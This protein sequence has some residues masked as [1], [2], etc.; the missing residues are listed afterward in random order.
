MLTK[1]ALIFFGLLFLICIWLGRRTRV[2]EP[3]EGERISVED[4]VILL[5]A[6]D[7]SVTGDFIAQNGGDYLG[8][9]E[10]ADGTSDA[11]GEDAVKEYLTYGQY[12]EIRKMVDGD[13]MNLPDYAERYEEE[14]PL[15]KEDWYA[16]Y[17]LML[18]HLDTESSIWETTVFLLK[19]DTE[20]GTAYTE[21]G[22][23][24][25][26]WQYHSQAFEEN[27]LQ[28]MRVYVKNSDLL[29]VI[30]V[31]PDKYEVKNVWIME[32]TEGV[33]ECFYHQIAF[34]AATERPVERERVA[35]LTFQNGRI[36]DAREKNEKVHGKLLRMTET[37]VEI[38]GCG[39][40]QIA[41]GMEV[42]K[43]YGSM[44]TQ[45]R[46]DLRI[47]YA[48]TDYVIDRGQ[49]CAALICEEETADRIR[50]LLKNTARNSN[51]FDTA[52]LVVDGETIQVNA[53]DLEVGERRSYQCAAL[54]D[55]ILLN[56][57]GNT[58]E[59]NAYRGTIECYRTD[60]GMALVNELAL[61]EYL[62]A[63]VPS[64]MP[65]SYPL[66][67]LKAQA[68]C[69]RTY[70]YRYILHAGVPELGAHVDDTTGYQVYHNSSENAAT[71]TAVKETKGV[72]LT[73]Q[74]EPAQNYYYSTSCGVGTNA[75]IW[76]SEAAQ[77]L[78]YL[79]AVRLN[80]PAYETTGNG[81]KAEVLSESMEGAG[82]EQEEAEALAASDG[83]RMEELQEEDRFYQF[84][85]AAGETDLE[86]EEPWYRWIYK[87][88]ELDEEAMQ[89]RIQERYASSPEC[90]LTKA[91]GGYYVS[92]PVERLGRI[93]EISV[94]ERGEGGVAEELLIETDTGTY[95]ILSEY[96]IR[97]VLCDRASSV[98]KQD[99]SQVVPKSLLPSGFF[100]VETGKEEGDVVGYTLTGGG[101]GHGVGMSQNG[102]RALGKEGCSYQGILEFFF[103][104]CEIETLK[105]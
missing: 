76:R 42:Y 17:R 65:A 55:K 49:V 47:G 94:V 60:E 18:A 97:S 66:E 81:R 104:G 37:E 45:S 4:V 11:G 71:T 56:L 28:Q 36:I 29:T 33:Q 1:L 59:D 16:A 58:R 26:P 62:Y 83:M 99:G 73:Y 23:D 9:P 38:E 98:M 31:L 74:G 46:S 32:T 24:Q 95:K 50:V 92:S 61:E 96:N 69:A 10:E 27:I 68:V 20:T 34:Q 12:I 88:E 8:R 93:R 70:A 105:R 52:E 64:E 101:Y 44:E 82:E 80:W 15:L 51:Y 14:D 89:S 7:I 19:I 75:G 103:P 100:V 102:A 77:D 54:T 5:Q 6:L 87:V 22:G 35:D 41:D 72:L 90:V 79:Q 57:E 67:S 48:D 2:R 25:A 30:D 85:T 40:Y 53:A 39:I 43:L 13:V 78:P 63:V 91:E 21:N 3:L 86:K 84:I